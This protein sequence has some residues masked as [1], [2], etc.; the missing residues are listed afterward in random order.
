MADGALIVIDCMEGVCLQTER[1]IQLAIVER[2][3]PLVVISKLDRAIIEHRLVRSPSSLINPE[4]SPFS[5]CW[6][7]A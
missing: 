1:V 6:A 5:S 2:V 3:K 4:N 7:E